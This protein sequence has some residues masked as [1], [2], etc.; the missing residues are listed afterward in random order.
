MTCLVLSEDIEGVSP[1]CSEKLRHSSAQALTRKSHLS[2][3]LTIPLASQNNTTL[4]FARELHYY[5]YGK[6]IPTIIIVP[7]DADDSFMT[8]MH[9]QAQDVEC[10]SCRGSAHSRWETGCNDPCFSGCAPM[11]L[12]PSPKANFQRCESNRSCD[13]LPR[14]PRRKVSYEASSTSSKQNT[15]WSSSR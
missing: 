3:K 12:T 1:V 11:T 15:R 7:C 4:F 13:S 2:P 10:E 6:M 14:L 8:T 5:Y 9:H